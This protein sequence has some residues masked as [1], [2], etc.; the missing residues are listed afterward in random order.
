GALALLVITPAA[1]ALAIALR[2]PPEGEALAL[3]TGMPMPT[4]FSLRNPWFLPLLIVEW[5]WEAPDA[6]V[7]VKVEGGRRHEW[8]APRRRALVEQVTRRITVRDVWGFAHVSFTRKEP[9]KVRVVP[10]VGALRNVPVVRALSGG[11]DFYDPLGA[12]QGD[13]ADMRAYGP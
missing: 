13:R 10:F 9:R 1:I 12:P 11:D 3:Q 8:I 4:G 7:R 2:N 5:T 6:E